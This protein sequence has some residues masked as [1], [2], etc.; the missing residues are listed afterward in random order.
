MGAQPVVCTLPE[1]PFLRVPI[2]T[3]ALDV[4]VHNDPG[5][6]RDRRT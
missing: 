4:E 2:R 6:E 5:Q 3:V 1:E